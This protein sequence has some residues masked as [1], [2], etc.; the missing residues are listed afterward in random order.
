MKGKK[1]QPIGEPFVAIVRTVFDSEA[2][3]RLPSL[4]QKIFDLMIRRRGPDRGKTVSLS[5]RQAAD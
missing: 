5:C 3:R 4:A 2:Y 1:G